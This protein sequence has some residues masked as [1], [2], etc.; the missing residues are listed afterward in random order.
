[1]TTLVAA[2]SPPPTAQ[3]N[4]R[5]MANEL[6]SWNPDLDPTYAKR[7]INNSFRRILDHRRW[8][9]CVLS[10]ILSV[11]S[12]YT[13]GT[14]TF[15]SGSPNVVG[16][17]TAWTAAMVGLQIRVGFSTPTS[18]ITAVTSATTLTMDQPWAPVTMTGVGYQIFTR[19]VSFGANVKLLLYVINQFQGYRCALHIPQAA[20]N[21]WD[22]W[23]ATVGFTHTVA[24]YSPSPA[25]E[26]LY[27]LYPI[28]ITQQGFPFLAY[29]QPPDFVNDGDAPPLWIRSDV[30]VLGAMPDAL[31][32]R[33]KNSK[34]YDPTTA[35][36]K[37]GQFEDALQKMARND[38][39]SAM[40]N[41]AWEFS[42][43]PESQFGSTFRQSHDVD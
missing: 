19:F 11:P 42:K 28:P 32:F 4:F 17:N 15:T 24:D 9:G 14:A 10:G 25:G 39:N 26:P 16:V 13:S 20:L 33:G 2:T 6:V 3:L 21:A 7:L 37:Q 31:L 29:T 23:R 30:V 22:A 43:F 41:L 40:R 38:D 35:K 5:Q 12:I 1:M 8:Y 36:F 34:Y 27:E 18:T